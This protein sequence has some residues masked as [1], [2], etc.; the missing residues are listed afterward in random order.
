MK[1]ISKALSQ[2]DDVL[3]QINATMLLFPTDQIKHAVSNLYAHMMEFLQRAMKWYTEARIK[4]FISA[5]IAPVSLKFK[6]IFE[7]ISSCSRI[8][9]QLAVYASQAEQ[10]DMH[11]R[12]VEIQR[13]LAENQAANSR[14]LL[15]SRR[16]TCE[17]QF[18][19]ILTF[20]ADSTT[21]ES[22]QTF[23]YCNFLSRR[24]RLRN[25]APA[26][27]SWR[28][29]KLQQWA[30]TRDSSVVLVKGSCL[31]RHT[32]KDFTVDIV[33]ML[34]SMSIPVV[35]ALSAKDDG[36]SVWRSPVDVLEQLSLQV[37]HINHS[38]L[39]D[40]SAA[41][42]AARFQSATTES[43]WFD[44]LELVL[45]GLPQIY[46]ALDVEVL[47]R[48]FG[49]QL[50][51]P[52]EFLRTFTNLAARGSKTVVKVVLVSFANNPFTET[53]FTSH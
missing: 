8:V 22:E 16:R 28:S 53:P 21:P 14:L 38:L 47:E 25:T 48:G 52:L 46:I 36:L 24:R 51:W 20:T 10:R 40:Q 23:Q 11:I 15:D 17:L 33:A 32:L 26:D 35:W 13:T 41:L 7:E 49:S 43:Q 1:Q 3:P 4:R 12:L 37:L 2:I 44:L 31:A 50:C 5:V 9:D 42:N 30:A 34:R 39:R 45:D 27:T 6:D 19:Q 18:S 29:H